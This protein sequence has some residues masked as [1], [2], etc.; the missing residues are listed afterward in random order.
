MYIYVDMGIDTNIF[1]ALYTHALEHITYL[2]V[3]E[4]HRWDARHWK[5]QQAMYLHIYI[6]P[7]LHTYTRVYVCI[8][9]YTNT[10]T[11]IVL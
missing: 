5:C 9:V 1:S 4:L 3:F 6:H 7:Y 10:Y 2:G 11:H 8:Y